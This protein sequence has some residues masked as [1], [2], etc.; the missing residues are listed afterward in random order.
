[1]YIAHRQAMLP[2]AQLGPLLKI[3]D[4]YQLQ[5]DVGVH[6]KQPQFHVTYCKPV[7]N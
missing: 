1:M 7:M 3:N 4:K 2:Y 5:L 6:V